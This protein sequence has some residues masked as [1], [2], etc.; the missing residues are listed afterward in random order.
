LRLNNYIYSIKNQEKMKRRKF[1]DSSLE[2]GTILHSVYFWLHKELSK[3]EEKDFL[4]Y[5]KV[6]AK[7]PGVRSINYG[8]P[9]PTEARD[10]VD[11]SYSYNLILTFETLEDITAYGIHPEHVKGAKQYSKYWTRVEVRDTILA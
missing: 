5:F 10:V 3:E 4:N 7:I 6:L 2:T 8:V 9:A 11:H 1:I